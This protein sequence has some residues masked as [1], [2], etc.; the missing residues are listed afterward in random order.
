MA[1]LPK[2]LLGIYEEALATQ[3]E[4]LNE[5]APLREQEAEVITRLHKVEAELKTIREKIME[6]E[7][8]RLEEA[9]KV[10]AALTPKGKS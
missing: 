1:K 2:E 6:I 4:V 3:K 10:I 9:L 7:K 5:L 8:P